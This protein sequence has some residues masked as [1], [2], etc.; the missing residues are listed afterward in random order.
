MAY[1]FT[2]FEDS[3]FSHSRR[4]NQNVK[5][6]RFVV[7]KVTQGHR[8]CHLIERIQL[9]SFVETVYFVPF[10]R[11]SKLVVTSHNF[12]CPTCICVPVIMTPVECH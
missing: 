5:L 11:H 7:I 4:K 1:L 6:V 2:E 12:S 9:S 10:S 3:S 8:Q